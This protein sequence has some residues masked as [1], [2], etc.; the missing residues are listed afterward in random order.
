MCVNMALLDECFFMFVAQL[1]RTSEISWD[2]S[3]AS[4]TTRL[5]SAICQS[6]AR[7]LKFLPPLFWS[8]YLELLRT[9]RFN[10]VNKMDLVIVWL[11]VL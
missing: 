9:S 2:V 4:R 10:Q 7:K 8:L 6:Q 1:Y 11:W 3:T 5:H